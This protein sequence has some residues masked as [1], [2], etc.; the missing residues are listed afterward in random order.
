LGLTP[1]EAEDVTRAVGASPVKKPRR[2][3][4]ETA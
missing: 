2:R 3:K 4:A 1:E